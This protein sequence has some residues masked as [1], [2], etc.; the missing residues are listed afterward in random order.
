MG[1]QQPLPTEVAEAIQRIDAA[2]PQ[3]LLDDWK[4]VRG[5][6]RARHTESQRVLPAASLAVQEMA[7]A[8]HHAQNAMEAMAGVFGRKDD[9][10]EPEPET[11]KHGKLRL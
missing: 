8:R 5:F 10:P 7:Q 9:E 2:I 4:K 1:S 11:A 3:E 6:C